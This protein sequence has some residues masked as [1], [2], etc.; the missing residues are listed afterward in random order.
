VLVPAIV[1]RAGDQVW[2]PSKLAKGSETQVS[3]V[4]PAPR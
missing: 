3:L 2:W 1:L 4:E